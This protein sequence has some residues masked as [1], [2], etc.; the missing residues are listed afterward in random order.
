MLNIYGSSNHKN[1]IE[2]FR[3]FSEAVVQNPRMI[4][5][6]YWDEYTW[7]CRD[8]RNRELNLFKFIPRVRFD[9]TLGLI[10]GKEIEVHEGILNIDNAN[11]EILNKSKLRMKKLKIK[12]SDFDALPRSLH[13]SSSILNTIEYIIIEQTS[14]YG[15]S[16]EHIEYSNF[17]DFIQSCSEI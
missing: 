8:L 14:D 2:A 16:Y 7:P 17:F 11:H 15:L 1:I 10:H 9:K 12:T 6:V 4:K 13:L 5:S 3:W